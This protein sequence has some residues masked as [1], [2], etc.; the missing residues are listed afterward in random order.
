[1]GNLS[2]SQPGYNDF[3]LVPEP[4]QKPG[5]QLYLEPVRR[6]TTVFQVWTIWRDVESFGRRRRRSYW[7]IRGVRT[8]FRSNCTG[9]SGTITCSHRSWTPWRRVATTERRSNVTLKYSLWKR[10]IKRSQ[11]GWGKAAKAENQMKMISQPI[12]RFLR[13]SMQ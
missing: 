13:T 7:S 9:P 4:V 3:N 5:T 10:G 2:S 8:A 1:M 6:R 11:T 12:F